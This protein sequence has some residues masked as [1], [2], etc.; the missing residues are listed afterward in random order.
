LRDFFRFPHT[1]HLAWLAAGS[2]RDDKVLSPD[3]AEE[4][5]AHDVVVEEKVDGANVGVSIDEHGEL[6]VQNRGAYLTRE[7]CHPQFK[8]F[9]RWLESRSHDLNGALQ[10]SLM[11]FG[12]WCYAVHSVRYTKLP[13]WF[14]AFDVFDRSRREF[15]SVARR[16]EL[17]GRLGLSVV[18]R[19]AA[20]HFSF[21]EMK[22]LLGQSQL[23][24]GAAEGIYIRRDGGDRLVARAKLV[25]PEFTQS[26]D[27]HWSRRALQ[28]NQLVG[29]SAW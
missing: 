14:L 10:P 16:D 18:P 21:D 17:A 25:R 6:R 27:G 22:R 11:L 12:E 26:I 19:I 9:W 2:P 15:W 8:P 5:L 13:D 23:T 28:A 7:D 4:L 20:G 24:D 1:P 3:Q 29:G